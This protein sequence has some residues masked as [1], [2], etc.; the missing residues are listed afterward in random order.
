M[1]TKLPLLCILLATMASA[2]M[3]QSFRG[4]LTTRYR[5]RWG[6]SDWADQDVF[7]YLRLS[8]GEDGQ[9]DISGAFSLRWDKD[10]L[11][12]ANEID[13]GHDNFRLYYGYVDITKIKRFDLRLGRQYVDE[14]EGFNLT[15]IKGV[16]SA[17][18]R[19]LRI[20]LFAGQPVSYYAS[21][22]GD[23]RA[24]GLTWSLRPD[25]RAQLRGSWIHLEEDATDSDVVTLAYRRAFVQGSSLYAT[26]RTLD[27]EIFNEL[28]GGSWQVTP[29]GFLVTGS[30]RRQEDTNASRSIYFGD[31]STIIGPSR[32]YHELTVD[33]TRPLRDLASVGVGYTRRELLHGDA[34]AGNQ[35]YGRLFLDVALTDQAL[36]GFTANANFSRWQTGHDD[37]STLGGS[38]S[39]RFG[40][41]LQLEVGSFY[42]EY[43][44]RRISDAP[45]E[46]PQERFDVR[47]NYL[48][49]EWRVLHRY[50]LRL[51]LDRTTDSTSEDAYYEA[52]LR[53]G[54][55]LGFLGK[56][57]GK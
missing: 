8:Y 36:H 54:L 32:P 47:S 40:E 27:F 6:S 53:F 14:A 33:L 43:D 50:R 26:A 44:L 49:G 48:R 13:D 41:H 2:A 45:D 4:E 23:E 30:Y 1:R 35:E 16:Y 46:I 21:I 18:W 12:R 25:D 20:G 37:S 19:H 39:H 55:D 17:P 56:G 9:H 38:L 28:V 15:G 22:H 31:L 42:T 57:S 10:L 34:S 7:T 24:G 51:D 11:T 3:A 52:E 29:Q 5:D